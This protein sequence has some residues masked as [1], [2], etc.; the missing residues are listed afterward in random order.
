[1]AIGGNHHCNFNVL[2]SKAGNLSSPFSIDR[3][4]AFQFQTNFGEKEMA[5]SRDA[6]TIPILSILI[7]WFCAI[8]ESAY[9]LKLRILY[10]VNCSLMD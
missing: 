4:A 8:I 9:K 5:L 6:T 2:V 7:N 3:G 10:K 1:M